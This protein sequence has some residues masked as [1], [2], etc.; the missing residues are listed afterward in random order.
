MCLDDI[1][2]YGMI[3]FLDFKKPLVGVNSVRKIT[4]RTKI[5]HESKSKKGTQSN[6]F[7]V[8]SSTRVVT[9]NR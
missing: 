6:F 7:N 5:I 8:E 1:V 3:L 9:D 4:S 2:F